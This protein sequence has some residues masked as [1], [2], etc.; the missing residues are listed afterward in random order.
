MYPEVSN[1]SGGVDKT[2]MIIFGIGI[3]FLIG[4]S[5]LMMYFVVRYRRKKH[6]KAIQIKER[7]WVE[8]TWIV[9]PMILVL[10]MFHYGYEAYRPMENPPDDAIVV[11]T[12]GKMWSWSFEY[13]NGKTS[14]ELVIP[15]N[16]AVKLDLISLDVIHGLFIPAFRVKQDVVPGKENFVWFIGQEY[17][18][19]EI[20]C[21]AYCGLDHSFMESKAIVVT[22]DRYNAWLDSLPEKKEEPEG[23]VLI[24][25]NACTGCHSIDGTDGVGPPLNDLFGSTIT[26][27]VDGTEKEVVVD[28]LYLRRAITEPNDEVVKGYQRG[29]MKSYKGVIKKDDIRKIVEYLK[30]LKK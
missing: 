15:I 27:L 21:S 28:E 8:I 18:E 7:S 11:K 25:Q 3:F 20:V 26:V 9:I 16:K 22:E 24:K 17:G 1:F 19:F 14:D 30:T 2:F 12:Y 5:I 13:P 29:V 10:L 23:L 6:P 4:I